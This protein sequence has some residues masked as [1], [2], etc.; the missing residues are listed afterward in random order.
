MPKKNKE[1]LAT[2]QMKKIVDSDYSMKDSSKKLVINYLN[3]FARFLQKNN[4][5][6]AWKSMNYDTIIKLRE[7]ELQGEGKV[8]SLNSYINIILSVLHKADADASN[9]FKWSESG[10][11]SYKKI[12]IKNQKEIEEKQFSLTEQEIKD[13]YNYEA[14]GTRKKKCTEVKDMFVLQCMTGQ[15]I[16]D[17]PKFFNGEYKIETESDG[18]RVIRINQKKTNSYAFIPLL[19]I[20]EEIISKYNKDYQFEDIDLTVRERI[21]REIGQKV[22]INRL[23]KFKTCECNKGKVVYKNHSEE[24]YKLLKTHIARHTFITLMINKNVPVDTIQLITGHSTQDMI[25][26]IYSHENDEHKAKTVLS[27]ISK[28][29]SG[30]YAVTKDKEQSDKEQSNKKQSNNV[31]SD[32]EQSSNVQ[33]NKEQSNNENVL[34]TNDKNSKVESGNTIYVQQTNDLQYEYYEFDDSLFEGYEDK[35]DYFIKNKGKYNLTNEE[36]KFVLQNA[37]SFEVGVPTLKVRKIINKL[38]ELKIIY[39]LR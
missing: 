21:I 18:N 14:K 15:R 16:S 1:E 8:T 22:K 24:A 20:A 5:S 27:D 3:K 30:I 37:N 35:S 13:I 10:L 11:S 39:R 28:I 29:D 2:L 19:P 36:Y 26:K 17:M 25:K 7:S 4:I 31:Q 38:L 32:K 12:P 33:S 6:D 34:Q 23:I 9:S